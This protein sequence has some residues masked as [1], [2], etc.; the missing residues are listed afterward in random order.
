[1]LG[2]ESRESRDQGGLLSKR[3]NVI[4]WYISSIF[5]GVLQ[6]YSVEYSIFLGAKRYLSIFIGIFFL[7][8]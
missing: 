1:M 2:L 8:R 6:V 7:G 5:I 4:R 3:G